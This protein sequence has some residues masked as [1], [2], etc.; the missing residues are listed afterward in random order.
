[1]ITHYL[2]TVRTNNMHMRLD[3]IDIIQTVEAVRPEELGEVTEKK[4]RNME[5]K[6]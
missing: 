1:M 6:I 4:R 3:V 5:I 2:R